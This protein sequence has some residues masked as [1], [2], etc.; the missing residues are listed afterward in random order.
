MLTHTVSPTETLPHS[1][2]EPQGNTYRLY[3]L[4]N[5]APESIFNQQKLQKSSLQPGR[6]TTGKRDLDLHSVSPGHLV[7]GRFDWAILI[8][9]LYHDR[10]FPFII[11]SPNRPSKSRSHLFS[12]R[13]QRC[14]SREVSAIDNELARLTLGPLSLCARITLHGEVNHC[15]RLRVLANGFGTLLGRERWNFLLTSDFRK[16]KGNPKGAGKGPTDN[17][18]RYR[19]GH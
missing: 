16:D 15:R 4:A 9:Q 14:A 19:S 11:S 17:I 5:P 13:G 8:A 3:R 1:L 7:I 18:H 10:M 12:K 2:D 6:L